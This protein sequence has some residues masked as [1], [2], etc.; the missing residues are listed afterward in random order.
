MYKLKQKDLIQKRAKDLRTHF[1]KEDLQM[2]NTPLK[3][4]S[5]LLIREM[6]IKT[7]IRLLLHIIQNGWNQ[8]DKNKKC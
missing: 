3:R 2:A 8:K 6:Q 1:S 4:C 7:T 5:T